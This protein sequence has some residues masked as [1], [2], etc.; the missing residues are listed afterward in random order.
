MWFEGMPAG[1]E[2]FQQNTLYLEQLV[3]LY[4]QISNPYGWGI[5]Y[6]EFDLSGLSEGFFKLKKLRGI[7]ENFVFFDVDESSNLQVNLKDL[8]NDFKNDKKLF[9]YISLPKNEFTPQANESSPKYSTEYIEVIDFNNKTEKQGLSFLKPNYFLEI[10]ES[11]SLKHDSLP[12]AQVKFNGMSFSLTNYAY[13]TQDISNLTHTLAVLRELVTKMKDK[14]KYLKNIKKLSLDQY[15]QLSN[16]SSLVFPLE[17]AIKSKDHPFNIYKI[18]AQGVASAYNFAK[19]TDL[20]N[21]EAYDHKNIA[22]SLYSLIDYINSNIDSIFESFKLH[23]FTKSKNSF[24]IQLKEISKQYLLVAIE[25]DSSTNYEDLSSWISGA[26]IATENKIESAKEQRSRGADR[27]KI[28][29]YKD[30]E[31]QEIPDMVIVKIQI[32]ETFVNENEILIIENNN[33]TLP[34]PPEIYLIES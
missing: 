28:E 30:F 29:N 25:K 34:V 16:V 31:I 21:I 1:P 17:A 7:N 27:S 9:I 18:L 20:P 15:S 13:P 3:S 32:K 33:D 23:K 2:V 10:A 26:T 6:S 19:K 24:K 14:V 5:S 8:K 22:V 11:S 12:L 4:T